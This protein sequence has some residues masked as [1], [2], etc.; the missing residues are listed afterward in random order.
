MESFKELPVIE[1]YITVVVNKMLC[2]RKFGRGILCFQL[3][4]ERVHFEIKRH[5]NLNEYL[6]E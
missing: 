6:D 3:D 1:I 5:L 4:T 2:D